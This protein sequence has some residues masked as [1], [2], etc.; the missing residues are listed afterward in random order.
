MPRTRNFAYRSI[1]SLWLI[2]PI[3]FVNHLFPK[4][5]TSPVI[6]LQKTTPI[7]S[8]PKSLASESQSSQC[9][10]LVELIDIL[11]ALTASRIRA[12]VAEHFS[13]FLIV[14]A[15]RMSCAPRCTKTTSETMWSAGS[16]ARRIMDCLSS[17]WKTSFSS[18]DVL[19]SRH[20][21]PLRLSTTLKKYLWQ[22][23][24]Y[25]AAGH[26]SIGAGCAEMCH[27]TTVSTTRTQQCVSPWLFFR[28]PCTHSYFVLT[29]GEFIPDPQPKRLKQSYRRSSLP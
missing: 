24:P 11:A 5:N 27:I 10:G 23:K 25:L 7:I 22:P 17:A 26:N 19:W 12:R 18:P 6:S 28:L 20:G 9:P 3:I 8:V 14:A 2:R 21:L 29:T 16:S 4:E 1:T 15:A 13:F